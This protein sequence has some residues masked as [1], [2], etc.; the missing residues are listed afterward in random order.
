MTVVVCALGVHV[1]FDM[2]K[3]GLDFMKTGFDPF[4]AGCYNKHHHKK[5]VNVL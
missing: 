1:N 5:Q 2:I 3:V 4:K